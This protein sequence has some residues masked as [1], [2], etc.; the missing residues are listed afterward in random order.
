MDAAKSVTATFALLP[1]QLTVATTGTGSGSVTSPAGIDCGSTC[2]VTVANGT[3]VT[4]TAAPAVGSTFTGWSGA[5]TGA[6]ATCVVSM[7]AAKSVSATFTVLT[8]DLTV[9]KAGTGSGT[10]TSSPAG[11]DCGATCVAT[12]AHGTNVTLTAVPAAGSSF[13][14]WNGACSTTSTTCIVPMSAAKSVTATF[15]ALTFHLTVAKAGTGNGSVTST[16]AGVTC[17]ATC[18]NDFANGSTVTL[19][20]AA[21]AGSSFTAWSGACSGASTTCTVSMSAARS[22]TA[23]FTLL[24]VHLTVAKAG[25]GNGS[26]TSS[27]GRHHLRRNV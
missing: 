8:Y 25:T 26:V 27:P 4:L 20:A 24:P 19:T 11:I 18:E 7:N 17:G 1:V 16:P 6:S 10:V 5:C 23:T 14:R 22:V 3:S 9:A 13:T 15:A 21:S 2:Q 12:L